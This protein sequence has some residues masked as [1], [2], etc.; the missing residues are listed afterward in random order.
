LAQPSKLKIES[1]ALKDGRTAF[2]HTRTGKAGDSPLK[3]KHAVMVNA[4]GL[5]GFARRLWQRE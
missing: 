4:L 2:K 5:I 3:S 1:K